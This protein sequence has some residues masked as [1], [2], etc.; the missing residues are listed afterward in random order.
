[1]MQTHDEI[2]EAAR[3]RASYWWSNRDVSWKSLNR[4]LVHVMREH[5]HPLAELVAQVAAHAN[6][7]LLSNRWQDWYALYL[8]S[9]ADDTL[10]PVPPHEWCIC[11]DEL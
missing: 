10:P 4:Q 9:L 11:A 7:L 1:M 5:R 8:Y 3:W 2:R 6:D